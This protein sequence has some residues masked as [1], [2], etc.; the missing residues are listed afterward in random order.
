MSPQENSYYCEPAAVQAA[1]RNENKDYNQSQ[2]A[3]WLGTTS[4]AGTGWSDETAPVQ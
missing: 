2:I 4:H 1:L 3:G